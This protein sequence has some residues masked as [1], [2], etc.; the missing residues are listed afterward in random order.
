MRFELKTSGILALLAAVAGGCAGDS[1]DYPS[2]AMRPFESGVPVETP[3]P[4]TPIRP[5]T[6]AARVAELRQA[7][8]AAHAAFVAQEAEAAR[9]ARAAAGLPFESNARATAMVAMADLDAK[10]AATAGTLAA[11]D[12][13]AAEA[14]GALVA[15]PALGAVQTEIAALVA[16]E[17]EAIARLWEVM[18]S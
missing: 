9:F 13:L 5:A 14:A 18:G 17:D 11:I 10:R 3:A 15:D 8:T 1:G 2:L 12:V 16:R 4:A 6:P 7:G